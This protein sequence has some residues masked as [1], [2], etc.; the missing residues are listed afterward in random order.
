MGLG[1]KIVKQ[2]IESY[3]GNIKLENRIKG[4]YSKGLRFIVEIPL[5]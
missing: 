4:D 2:V 5:N 3:N 1:L